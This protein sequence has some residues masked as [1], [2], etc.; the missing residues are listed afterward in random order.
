VDFKV[1]GGAKGTVAIGVQRTGY[2]TA[3]DQM[4]PLATITDTAFTL[5]VGVG[6]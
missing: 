6:F 2:F 4:T 5:K 3:G 1:S